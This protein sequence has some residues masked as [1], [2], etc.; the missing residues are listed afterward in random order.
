MALRAMGVV[1]A[2]ETPLLV[3]LFQVPSNPQ[4]PMTADSL[5]YRG[6]RVPLTSFATVLVSSP[7]CHFTFCIEILE[8]D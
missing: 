2:A 3:R 6:R 5:P 7:S 1:R 4:Q 8:G